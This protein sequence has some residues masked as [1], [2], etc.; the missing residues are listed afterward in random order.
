[1]QDQWHG[2]HLQFILHLTSASSTAPISRD[3]KS[4]LSESYEN[5]SDVRARPIKSYTT[6]YRCLK[7]TSMWGARDWHAPLTRTT[8]FLHTAS[9]RPEKE[10]QEMKTVSIAAADVKSLITYC[11]ST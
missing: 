10:G 2:P 1:M 3:N 9:H 7:R 8:A 5:P 4:Q 11:T 6:I